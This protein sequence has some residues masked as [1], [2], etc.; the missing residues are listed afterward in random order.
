MSKVGEIK[1]CVVIV[2]QIARRCFYDLVIDRMVRDIVNF[3]FFDELLW[4]F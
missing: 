1:I 3:L 2:S 4:V